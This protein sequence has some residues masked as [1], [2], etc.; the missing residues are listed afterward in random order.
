M[1]SLESLTAFLGWCTIIN[2]GVFMLGSMFLVVWQAPARA[3]HAR[4]FKLSETEL[5]RAYFQFLGQYKIA[6]W[7]LNLAPY[8]ALKIMA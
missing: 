5:S 6:I 1:N 2:I 7:I 3:I 8:I 4:M